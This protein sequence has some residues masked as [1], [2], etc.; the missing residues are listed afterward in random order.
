MGG[1]DCLIYAQVTKHTSISTDCIGKQVGHRLY[2][3]ASWERRLHSTDLAYSPHTY[4]ML[5]MD[6]QVSMTTRNKVLGENHPS[7]SCSRK[8]VFCKYHD[9][10][11]HSPNMPKKYIKDS[12]FGWTRGMAVTL[13]QKVLL[14]YLELMLSPPLARCRLST[15]AWG[16]PWDFINPEYHMCSEQKTYRASYNEPVRENPS[17]VNGPFG[18]FLEM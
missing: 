2:R 8:S 16:G 9:S 3:Q 11:V 4:R 17:S 14:L 7:K 5:L 15:S 18:S 1:Q 6:E 12:T 10:I 13:G